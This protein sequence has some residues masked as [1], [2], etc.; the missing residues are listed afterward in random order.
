MNYM[1]EGFRLAIGFVSQ[2]RIFERHFLGNIYYR[3]EIGFQDPI[4]AK[5]N[6]NHL[7]NV[8]HL[9]IFKRIENIGCASVKN[10]CAPNM[11]IINHIAYSERASG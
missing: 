4:G 5:K 7:K 11:M 8:F 1:C 2:I 9:I 10:S 3:Q 6:C